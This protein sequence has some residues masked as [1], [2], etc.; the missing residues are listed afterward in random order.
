MDRYKVVRSCAANL[1][2]SIAKLSNEIFRAQLPTKETL[3]YVD[4]YL[5]AAFSAINKQPA[6][7]LPELFPTAEIPRDLLVAKLVR[8]S[9]NFLSIV[10]TNPNDWED[11]YLDYDLNHLSNLIR[12][13]HAIT[14]PTPLPLEGETNVG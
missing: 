12:A 4:I 3:E 13:A 10:F 8:Y 7:V 2:I 1:Q 9:S 6:V 14:L 11:N 5:A